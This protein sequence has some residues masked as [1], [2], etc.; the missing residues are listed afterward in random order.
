[1]RVKAVCG[2]GVLGALLGCGKGGSVVGPE[3]AGSTVK[4]EDGVAAEVAS[5]AY[6]PYLRQR[7]F[8]VRLE[9]RVVIA[10]LSNPYD[11]TLSAGNLR[12]VFMSNFNRGSNPQGFIKP[13]EG[14]DIGPKMVHAKESI[15]WSQELPYGICRIETEVYFG[16]EQRTTNGG[17]GGYNIG[18][19]FIDVPGSEC[20]KPKKDPSD[21]DP[22]CV[23]RPLYQPEVLELDDEPVAAVYCTSC[24]EGTFE[25]PQGAC[26]PVVPTCET[27]PNLCP[28]PEPN[29]E[30]T[31]S[32][33]PEPSP[34]P[35]PEP[36]ICFYNISGP[37]SQRAARCV[38]FAGGI[39]GNWNG[40]A[41]HCEVPF[42]GIINNS[43]N[44]TPGQ[45]ATGCLRKQDQ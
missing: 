7:H 9:G 36:G 19:G 17:P 39:G 26:Q 1:M 15:E 30:P 22:T 14:D 3:S 29:P 43:F 12:T 45:S 23:E 21:P 31:P 33:T 8:S 16:G 6:D 40:Q 37:P 18:F 41:N 32:P 2:L 35:S 13:Q 34:T 42:P 4:S 28:D 27:N 5:G 10:K 20:Y 11:H 24:P 25:L 38:I 44:L